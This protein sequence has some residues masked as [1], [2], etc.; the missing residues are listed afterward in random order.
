MAT[1]ASWREG[2]AT[3]PSGGRGSSPLDNVKDWP[4]KQQADW[5][6][7]NAL[8]GNDHLGQRF[9]RR[10][11]P[12]IAASILVSRYGQ[13]SK[14]PDENAAYNAMHDLLNEINL[15]VCLCVNGTRSES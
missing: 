3:L 6:I 7:N 11:M 4:L 2:N 5:I 12:Q 9:R 10:V 14:F 15:Q 1:V 8:T 13:F